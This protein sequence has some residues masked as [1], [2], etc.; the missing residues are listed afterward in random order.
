MGVIPKDIKDAAS[1]GGDGKYIKAEEF[2][3]KGLVLKVVSFSK[4]RAKNPKFGANEKDAL[5]DQGLLDEGETFR[6]VFET[7][8]LD[9]DGFPKQRIVESKSLAL[10]I[11]F[12]NCDPDEGEWIRISKEGKMDDTRYEVEK[13]EEP[14]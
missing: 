14:K 1:A 2:E 12:K 11:G 8:D 7:K 3:G 4:I 9:A 10:F 5:M 13:S 6:Y